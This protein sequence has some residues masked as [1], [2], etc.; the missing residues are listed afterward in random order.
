MKILLLDSYDSFTF[1]LYQYL[2]ILGVEVEV[3]RNDQ[4]PKGRIE[5]PGVDALVLSPGPGRPSDA[6][7]LVDLVKKQAHRLPILGICLGHQ[8]LAQALGGRIVLA[9]ELVHGKPSRVF[10]DGR[11]LYSG[12]PNPFPAIRYHSLTVAEE[13]LPENLE[14]SA[15]TADGE[16]MGIRLAGRPV[17]GVQFHPESHGTAAGMDLLDNFLELAR[18]AR[19]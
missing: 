18:G 3:V 11:S 10:H 14:I 16:I 1:N 9:D 6:G 17:E 13:G 8:A 4:L 12:L 5:N 2:R 15:H 7:C 19:S